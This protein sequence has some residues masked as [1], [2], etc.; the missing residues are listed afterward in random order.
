MASGA[1]RL[2]PDAI[3]GEE[4]ADSERRMQEVDRLL[5]MVEEFGPEILT[6]E[7]EALLIEAQTQQMAQSAAG[8]EG[9]WENLAERLDEDTL[10][11]LGQQIIEWVDADEAGRS[12]WK[13]REARGIRMMG[14][15]ENVEGGAKFP[16]A[17]K[18]V[19][20]L[21]IEACIQFQ[22]RA[23]A[24]LWPASG[25]V[26]VTVAGDMTPEK[27][28]QAE[29]VHQYM[30]YQY[31]HDMPG[32]FD[33]EDQLLMR[34]P[35]SGSAF[36]KVFYDA[37]LGKVVRRFVPPEDFL[38]PYNATSLETAPR[39]THIIRETPAA[40]R[41]KMKAGIY[42]QIDIGQ[43]ND[44]DQHDDHVQDEIDSV[45]GRTN[46]SSSEGDEEYT[47]YE[48]HVGLDLPG[49]EDPQGRT[50]PYIVV[51]NKESQK[52]LSI[53][54]NWMPEDQLCRK[55]M[56]FV[57]RKFLPGLGFYGFGFIHIIG[58]LQTAATGA[59]RAMLDSAMM[60]T[61]QGGFRSKS[62]NVSNG[63]LEL[64]PGEWVEVNASAE[65]LA[66]AFYTPSFKEPPIALFNLFKALTE[67][68]QRL[69]TIP[70]A[71]VGDSP[72][73]APVGTT[74]ALIEQATKVFSAI[75]ARQHEAYKREFAIVSE[76]NY[77]YGPEE[78]VYELAN[79]EARMAFKQDFDSRI[80]IIPVSDPNI[81]TSTQR[82]MGAQA[83]LDLSERAPDLY[84]R[85]A[86]HRRMLEAIR[87]PNIDEVLPPPQ[88]TPRR[89]PVEENMAMVQQQ[90]VMALI[91]QDHQA[92]LIVH[93]HWFMTLPPEQQQIAQAAYMAHVA[94]HLAHA[95]RLQIEQMMGGAPVVPPPEME[96]QVPPEVENEV[97]RRVA[98]AVQSAMAGMQQAQP[99]A[100]D[101][102]AEEQR[103]KD[104]A[105]AREQDRKD[106]IAAREQARKD[107]IAQ[108]DLE[109]K[110]KQ[111]EADLELM[112]VKAGADVALR[113]QAAADKAQFEAAKLAAQP[114]R[115]PGEPE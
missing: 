43:P 92:H 33:E 44:D 16:G 9:H 74:L 60:A 3:S 103:R 98:L 107:A 90:P 58:G 81:V 71:L 2:V 68:G 21:M 112:G 17:S 86:V 82:V 83:L 26:N 102:I 100:V 93:Q 19:H 72:T 53:R 24:E 34:L 78:Y 5:Q 46:A 23:I 50:L 45:E 20:P 29:R 18:A 65:E 96:G 61:I 12:D 59:L 87:T 6:P 77:L 104:E 32:A 110:A 101:P 13:E 105:A 111:T 39:Y 106:A 15:S 108:A 99:P 89:G 25:P 80:D 113:K 7:E 66:K 37:E 69:G 95:Y 22:A 55:R 27:A 73:N 47:E 88:E 75:H 54:R 1:Y 64:V 76:L 63:R 48:T 52:V 10:R 79:G 36:V 94:E 57:H 4:Y 8:G 30:S 115:T 91:D 84:D 31:L 62:I 14:V 109:R 42:R 85:R 97:A 114:P 49:F 41:R 11:R 35:F 38:V 56:H 70:D 67:M 51:V 40:V 28:E